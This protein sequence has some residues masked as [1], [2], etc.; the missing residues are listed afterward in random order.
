MLDEY[1]IENKIIDHV[2]TD[3]DSIC[4]FFIFV[5]KP[6]CDVV[7]EK[8][9]DFLFEIIAKNSLLKRF[10]TS[11]EFWENF[12]VRKPKLKRK[13]GYFDVESIGD[14]TL[15]TLALNYKDYIEVFGSQNI[16]K[17]TPRLKEKS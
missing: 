10:D 11:H 3:T 15:V 6:E 2:L 5:C 9:R 16:N 7:D 14:P 17:K 1:R 12:S 4:L 8:V 13:L